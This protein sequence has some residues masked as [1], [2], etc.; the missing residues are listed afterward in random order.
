[1]NEDE[2]FSRDSPLQLLQDAMRNL[3]LAS[4]I[5]DWVNNPGDRSRAEATLRR[6]LFFRKQE[7]ATLLEVA[8]VLFDGSLLTSIADNVGGLWGILKDVA[9]AKNEPPN[10]T[11]VAGI[12]A[13]TD[14]KE[15]TKLQANY[16]KAVRIS[17]K[18]NIL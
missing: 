3:E 16:F 11:R 4:Y 7:I 14:D 12:F 17:T 6:K 9:K 1:M 15:T 10:S 2:Y 8:S 13:L 18:Q 5:H